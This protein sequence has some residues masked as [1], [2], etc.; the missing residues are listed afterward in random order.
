MQFLIYPNGHTFL[1]IVETAM[2]GRQNNVLTDIVGEKS[3]TS[4]TGIIST[5]IVRIV[6]AGMKSGVKIQ[7]VLEDSIFTVNGTIRHNIVQTVGNGKKKPAGTDSVAD[8]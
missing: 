1:S 5:I 2:S 4:V 6:R 3:D 8:A 7:S